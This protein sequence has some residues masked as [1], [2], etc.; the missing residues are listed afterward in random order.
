MCFE[1]ILDPALSNISDAEICNLAYDDTFGLENPSVRRRALPKPCDLIVDVH[2]VHSF[3]RHNTNRGKDQFNYP[4]SCS[5]KV[6]VFGDYKQTQF[7]LDI[8]VNKS[9][10]YHSGIFLNESTWLAFK[11]L[12][13]NNNVRGPSSPVHIRLYEQPY[14]NTVESFFTSWVEILRRHWY[15]NN[16]VLY[17]EN[18][19]KATMFMKELSAY[20]QKVELYQM[21]M[22]SDESLKSA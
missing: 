12:N 7:L 6:F 11:D 18:D 1:D 21:V 2:K 4:S 3:V 22:T 20:S 15:A 13:Q 19:A 14:M 16:D 17:S 8:G 5:P 10:F 9:I